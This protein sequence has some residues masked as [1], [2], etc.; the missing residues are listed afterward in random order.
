MKMMKEMSVFVC[1]CQRSGTTA[2]YEALTRHSALHSIGADEKELW[3]FTELF[4]RPDYDPYRHHHLDK[5]FLKE[6]VNFI[7]SFIRRH[8][9]SQNGH[10]V[11]GHP[12]NIVIA[13]S[14]HVLLP[15]AKFIMLVRDPLETVISM[16]NAP[17]AVGAG[18][19]SD[20][21]NVSEREIENLVEFW[22]SRAR[23]VLDACNGRFGDA[24]KVVRHDRLVADPRAEMASIL[25][26]LNLAKEASPSDYLASTL[27]NSSFAFD[28]F[29]LSVDDKRSKF[30][31]NR[32]YALSS[33]W[34]EKVYGLSEP[35]SS[36]LGYE[37]ASP[38]RPRNEP[39]RSKES[40]QSGEAEQERPLADARITSVELVNPPTQQPVGWCRFGEE[41]ALRVRIVSPVPIVNGSISFRVRDASGHS[42]FGTTTFDERY[43]LPE[44]WETGLSVDFIFSAVIAPGKY[45][46]DVAINSVSER[47]YS[48][49]ILLHQLEGAVELTVLRTDTR[50]VHYSFYVPVVC[51]HRVFGESEQVA[52]RVS[53]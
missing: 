11:T 26:F 3:F 38:A 17:F 13:P 22:R 8:C 15:H 10:Y 30:E 51:T 25:E 16:L 44:N 49:N 39:A 40:H 12:S 2:L 35:E 5:T 14:L 37:M 20:V 9:G 6:A 18:W 21:D 29:S 43:E 46:F 4:E 1:G 36:Q 33:L 34:A 53:Q 27:K 31:G 42:F 32:D 52:E 41:V 7:D 23:I 45:L 50:P 24:A 48:D 28:A 47:N 19:R